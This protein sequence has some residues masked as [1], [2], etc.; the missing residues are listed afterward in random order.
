MQRRCPQGRS[1][2]STGRSK[3][4]GHGFADSSALVWLA[5]CDSEDHA[6]P[7]LIRFPVGRGDRVRYSGRTLSGLWGRASWFGSLGLGLWVCASWF[8]SL[9]LGLWGWVSG[10][11]P[12]GLCLWVWVSGFGYL[13]WVWVSG[14]GLVPSVLSDLNFPC[15][16]APSSSCACNTDVGESVGVP[17][18]RGLAGFREL[19]RSD[20]LKLVC[21]ARC[22]CED[23]ALPDSTRLPV[24]LKDRVRCSGRVL[25]SSSSSSCACSTDVGESVGVPRTRGLTGFREL[26]RLVVLKLV[27]LARCD[28][29][30]RALLDSIRLP[31]GRRDRVTCSGRIL[32]SSSSC[33][34]STNVGKSVGVPG[35][36]RLAG[37]R[38]LSRIVVLTLVSTPRAPMSPESSR[39]FPFTGWLLEGLAELLSCLR[40]ARSVRLPNILQY[41]HANTH[42]TITLV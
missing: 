31:V 24:G 37:F 7:D 11:V 8:G 28:S 42:V 36:R 17:G 34:C 38:K 25:N 20:V 10:Y 33:G 39:L 5:R 16:A 19:S 22:D 4:T 6:L 14:F 29:E 1:A 13:G 3:Q 32:N 41:E 23:H 21:L 26:S 15:P 35:T 40:R 18:T 27:C 12:L 30:D 2:T 9:G